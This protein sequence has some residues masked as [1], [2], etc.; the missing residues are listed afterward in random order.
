MVFTRL[1]LASGE[2]K[3][4][5]EIFEILRIHSF[6][7]QLC[8]Y[9]TFLDAAY[10]IGFSLLHERGKSLIGK[11]LFPNDGVDVFRIMFFKSLQ[12]QT[13]EIFGADAVKSKSLTCK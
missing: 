13:N 3:L 11:F 8:G 5:R 4:A 6:D 7:Y 9:K 2:P 10:V 12:F 1:R